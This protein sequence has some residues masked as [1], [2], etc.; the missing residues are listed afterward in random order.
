MMFSIENVFLFRKCRLLE[1]DTKLMGYSRLTAG[2]RV[3]QALIE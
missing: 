1:I 3:T 2:C